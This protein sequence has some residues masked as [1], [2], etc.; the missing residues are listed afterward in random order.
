MY[1]LLDATDF[2]A[3]CHAIFEPRLA[4][5]AYVV[6]SSNDGCVISRSAKARSIGVKMGVPWFQ[7]KHLQD[8]HN[9]F[10]LSA[11]FSLYGSISSRIHGIISGLS[12][13]V[14]VFSIDEAF[15]LLTGYPGDPAVRVQRVR[16]R[17]LQWT[18]MPT[19]AG[20]GATKTLA[21]LAS[22]ISKAT[23]RKPGSYP[24]HMAGLCNLCASPPDE[25]TD[26]MSRTPVED[27]WGVGSRYAKRLEELGVLSALDLAR[28]DPTFARQQFGVVLERTI[29]ELNG[30]ACIPLEC[31][32]QP[33]KQMACTRS[34]GKPVRL[35]EPLV[36][37]AGSFAEHVAIKMRRRGSVTRQ[38]LVF[39]MTSPFK[40]G[41]RFYRT[42]V[43]ELGAFTSDTR[44]IVSAA[45]HGL[46]TIFEPGYNIVRV[47]VMLLDL[48][49][50]TAAAKQEAFDFE[51]PISERAARLMSA[52]D[53]INDRF[54]K[55]TIHVA[56]TQPTAQ[57]QRQQNKCPDYM[58][59]WAQLPMVVA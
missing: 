7:I 49:P 32:P 50:E 24:A 9:L 25:L 31:Q 5:M 2:Y 54:G 28:M 11:N 19:G 30:V 15:A 43:V 33:R 48:V 38:V 29:R 14:E 42:T 18:G 45:R 23:W 37:I 21:K 36:D 56:S 58:T 27:V 52:M 8:S 16:D 1:C 13:E 17:I 47:G 55:H 51:K 4:D 22:H 12:A 40:P 46:R 44:E 53:T 10:S 59:N 39:A 57:V 41:P 6:L 3:N 35:R 34:L 26:C 20:I